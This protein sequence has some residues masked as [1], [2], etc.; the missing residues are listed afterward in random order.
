MN[1]VW[2]NLARVWKS[3]FVAFL[4]IALAHVMML[5]HLIFTHGLFS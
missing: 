1:E 5:L 3:L 2:K 4:L